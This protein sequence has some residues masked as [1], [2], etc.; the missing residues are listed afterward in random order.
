MRCWV[1]FCGLKLA[2]SGTL[3]RGPALN[4][5]MTP[6]VRPL[7]WQLAQLCQPSLERRLRR[8]LVP[9]IWSKFP[10]EEKNI[11]APTRLVSPTEPGVGKSEL[12]TAAMTVSFVKSTTETL[13]ETKLA[14]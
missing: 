7:K 6:S 8:E 14:T 3:L 9:G 4:C 11:S 2:W 10:R 5:H 12:D 13:R 1:R